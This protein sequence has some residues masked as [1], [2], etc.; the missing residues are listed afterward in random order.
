MSEAAV[1]Y[2]SLP[3]YRPFPAGA[4]CEACGSPDMLVRDHCHEHGWVR[5]VACRGCNAYLSRIDRGKTPKVKDGHLAA[6]LAIWNN[7]PDCDRLD[8]ADLEPVP[9]PKVRCYPLPPPS[10]RRNRVQRLRGMASRQGYRLHKTRRIDPR[11]TDYGTFQ[12]IPEKGKAKD[13]AD[14]DAVEKFLTK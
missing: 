9:P 2:Q 7:C 5:G 11:A 6:L 4:A 10:D 12:L 8:A 1:Q 13:F 3:Y 14:I